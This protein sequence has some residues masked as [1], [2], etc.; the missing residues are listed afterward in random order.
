MNLGPH[1]LYR[2]RAAE[3]FLV[4]LGVPIHGRRVSAGGAYAV[5][6]ERLHALPAGLVSLLSTSA[7]DLGGKLE[8]ARFMARLRTLDPTALAGRT[9]DDWIR[10]IESAR[11]RSIVEALIRVATYTSAPELLSAEVAA[12][13]LRAAILDG[14]TYVDG[15]W[16]SLV[17]AVAEMAEARGVVVE[18][19]R[20]VEAIE[21][22]D[23][24]V[25]GVRV[26]GEMLSCGA[27]LI[28][29]G[30]PDTARAMSGSQSLARFAASAIPVR[31]AA[32][33]V[34]LGARIR[35]QVKF[36]MGLD[37]PLYFSVHSDTADVA[38]E[39][40]SLLHAAMY[41]RP[42]EE[43]DPSAIE[44]ELGRLVDRLQ[45]GWR[46]SV[47]ASRFL[48][49]LTVAHALPDGRP[50]PPPRVP[51]IEGLWVAGD[52]VGA[53]DRTELLLDASLASAR[54]AADEIRAH[55]AAKAAA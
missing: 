25:A 21:A 41:L 51:E 24:R 2:G 39:G 4:H 54:Q 49:R 47:V 19:G 3:R 42:G 50:R 31:A 34:A 46:S 37:R 13:Q 43:L 35:R 16:Q 55:L 40:G 9:V 27:V 22:R 44:A 18:R 32:L 14:V 17:D 8:L 29:A 12:D 30:G 20:R 52:W 11:A 23:G 6:G 5:D 45:P 7:L 1:A 28:A 48:P 26:D 36:A 53:G 15:G 10:S 33:D 38:P